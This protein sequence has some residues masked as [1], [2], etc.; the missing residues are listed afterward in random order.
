MAVNA[1]HE[2]EFR[3]YNFT[4]PDGAPEVELPY[5]VGHLVPIGVRIKLSRRSGEAECQGE[6]RVFGKWRDRDG[7]MTEQLEDV[8]FPGGVHWTPQWVLDL[9][10]R[11]CPVGWHLAR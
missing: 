1:V 6:A 5:N 7:T 9:M 4:L 2:S 3:T 10:R 11:T 8:V